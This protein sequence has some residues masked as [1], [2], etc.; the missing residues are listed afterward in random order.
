MHPSPASS[1]FSRRNALAVLAGAGPAPLLG[2]GTA[3]ARAR[4]TTVRATAFPSA[5]TE[6][7]RLA[8]TYRGSD[9][10]TT[11]QYAPAGA[12]H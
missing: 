5:E 1:P 2:S 7:L 8:A 6:R 10:I 9:F 11:G 3:S 12:T 4:T